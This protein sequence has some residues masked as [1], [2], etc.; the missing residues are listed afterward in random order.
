MQDLKLEHVSIIHRHGARSPVFTLTHFPLI[1]AFDHCKLLPAFHQSVH[2]TLDNHL[3][4]I[5]FDGDDGI[6][7]LNKQLSKVT[8]SQCFEG[9]LTDAGK[10]QMKSLGWYLRDTYINTMGLLPKVASEDDV[11][12]RST[13]YVRTL[14]SLQYLLVG[15]FPRN[16]IKQLPKVTVKETLDENLIPNDR[17]CPSLLKEI[18]DFRERFQESATNR[19]LLHLTPL[20]FWHTMHHSSLANQTYRLYD[21]LSCMKGNNIPYP[22]GIDETHRNNLEELTIDLWAR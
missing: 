5:E 9:Q 6:H 22:E 20:S 2:Q 8:K 7:H 18:K 4:D 17:N 3:L 15:L 14:E 19:F 10:Q 11:S 16:T 1:A 12:L 13:N 21:V